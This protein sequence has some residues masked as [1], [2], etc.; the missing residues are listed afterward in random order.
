[1]GDEY[2]K[3]VNQPKDIIKMPIEV[4]KLLRNSKGTRL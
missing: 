2:I 3:L 1:M 4:V